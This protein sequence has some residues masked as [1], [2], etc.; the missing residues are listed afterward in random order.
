MIPGRRCANSAQ[1]LLVWLLG[2]LRGV[3]APGHCIYN[4]LF[5][6]AELFVNLLLSVQYCHV[7]SRALRQQWAN[8]VMRVTLMLPKI[9]LRMLSVY[10][11]GLELEF[12][13][14]FGQPLGNGIQHPDRK[15]PVGVLQHINISIN[16]EHCVY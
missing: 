15:P 7:A 11:L 10:S 3:V 9:K 4:C 14:R 16:D 1:F 2:L 12:L 8:D 6:V 5:P 13:R